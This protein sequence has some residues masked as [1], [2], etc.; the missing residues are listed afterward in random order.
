[1]T[2]SQDSQAVASVQ[3]SAK[4]CLASPC[5][6]DSLVPVMTTLKIDCPL[7][8]ISLDHYSGPIAY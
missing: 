1:M 6:T 4:Y 2:K 8:F 3:C 5:L 7:V